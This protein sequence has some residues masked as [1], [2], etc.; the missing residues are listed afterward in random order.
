MKSINLHIIADKTKK[1]EKVR[2]SLIKSH[3]NS[4]PAACDYIIVIGGDGFMLHSL[5]KLQKYNKPFYG[6]NTGNRGFLLNKHGA[7]NIISKNKKIIT[8]NLYPL[9]A[10]IKLQMQQKNNSY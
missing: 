8:N 9:E 7:G 10:K 2:Q 4:T 1:A 6:V 5:K 3:S